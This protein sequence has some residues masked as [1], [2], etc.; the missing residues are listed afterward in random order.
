MNTSFIL[1]CSYSE[2]F[3]KVS[4]SYIVCLISIALTWNTLNLKS[5]PLIIF[6]N[7]YV[8]IFN[9]AKSCNFPLVFVCFLYVVYRM[10]LFEEFLMTLFICDLRWNKD[11]FWRFF[12]YI[13]FESSLKDLVASIHEV[14]DSKQLHRI[15]KC[16]VLRY[17]DKLNTI[18]HRF[19]ESDC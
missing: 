15:A 12:N 14:A 2:A 17:L 9:T 3:F 1:S 10:S 13:P 18:G 7:I 11:T 16:L 6:L 8:F 19:S 5:K 4:F